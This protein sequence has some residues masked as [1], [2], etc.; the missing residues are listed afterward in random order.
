MPVR[1]PKTGGL[2]KTWFV[3]SLCLYARY[4]FHDINTLSTIYRMLYISS[5]Y[6]SLLYTIYHILSAINHI[7]YIRYLYTILSTIY[8]LC[9]RWG[10]LPICLPILGDVGVPRRHAAQALRLLEPGGTALGTEVRTSRQLQPKAVLQCSGC[11][12]AAENSPREAEQRLPFEAQS[13]TK[14]LRFVAVGL[15]RH[16]VTIQAS[17]PMLIVGF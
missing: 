5:T 3:R 4:F 14:T 8:H 15:G 11:A 16:P 7:L 1:R 10:H 9:G 12:H 2:Q 17:A 13:S 6:T